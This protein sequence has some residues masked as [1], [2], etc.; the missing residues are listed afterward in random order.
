MGT[1][2]K[3]TVCVGSWPNHEPNR[4][5]RFVHE[6]TC[7]WLVTLQT[8]LKGTAVPLKRG[9]RKPEKQLSFKGS[10]QEG[11]SPHFSAV[12]AAL[13]GNHSGIFQPVLCNPFNASKWEC[14]SSPMVN[15]T[16]GRQV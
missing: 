10:A 1:N 7:L 12:F 11:P 9:C 15:R 2:W 13:M 4:T 6:P 3:N 16:G 5:G 8:P 14:V